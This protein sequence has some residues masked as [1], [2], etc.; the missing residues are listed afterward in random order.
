MS[1]P[2]SSLPFESPANV[3]LHVR[4]SN[5][6]SVQ[7]FIFGSGKAEASFLMKRNQRKI[8]WTMFYRRLHKKGLT[9]DVS[10]RKKVRCP[11]WARRCTRALQLCA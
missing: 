1:A 9:E 5:I 6:I 4:A 8:S 10:K 2:Q 11:I 7:T 3:Q